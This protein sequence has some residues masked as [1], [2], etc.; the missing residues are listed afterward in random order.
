MKILYLLLLTTLS[1]PIL[2]QATKGTTAKTTQTKANAFAAFISPSAKDAKVY[3]IAPGN[4]QKVS[5]TFKVVFGLTNM[6]IASA[7]VEFDNTGHHHL[8]INMDTLPSMTA[9]LP[10]SA[11]LIHYGKGQTEATITLPPGKHTLQLI[12]AN[13]L[14]IPHNPPVM[15]EK[16]TVYVE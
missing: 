1:L 2:A 3:F 8:L 6:G 5:Q 16:I 9:P 11:Q 14:H 4:G 7:G 12:F 10:A 15:S 13:Y